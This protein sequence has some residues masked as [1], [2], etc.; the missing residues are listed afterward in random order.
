LLQELLV[1]NPTRAADDVDFLWSSMLS[2]AIMSNWWSDK[3]FHLRMMP[4]KSPSNLVEI[5]SHIIVST[6]LS[7]INGPEPT[8][9]AVSKNANHFPDCFGWSFLGS[10]IFLWSFELLISTKTTAFCAASQFYTHL[11]TG[12]LYLQNLSACWRTFSGPWSLE[13]APWPTNMLVF[14]FSP[15]L[16]HC[17]GLPAFIGIFLSYARGRFHLPL[18]SCAFCPASPSV[19]LFCPIITRLNGRLPCHQLVSAPLDSNTPPAET[20]FQ[21]LQA[22]WGYISVDTMSD[23][24]TT[25]GT[26][27]TTQMTWWHR[28]AAN[29]LPG[30][31]P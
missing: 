8:A 14:L 9:H 1:N 11:T 29:T 5:G 2:D 6:P 20:I 22:N 26:Y 10:N 13:K 31:M 28:S 7:L 23:S 15:L 19:L 3:N 30:R 27:R 25:H 17:R 16:C 18:Y 24:L 21:P 12:L 4:C